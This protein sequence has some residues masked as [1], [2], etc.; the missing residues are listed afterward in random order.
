MSSGNERGVVYISQGLRAQAEVI[1][2]LRSLHQFHSW[3]VTVFGDLPVRGAE[4]I[5]VID[6]GR[7]GRF[8]K[9]S[10]GKLTPYKF[11]LFLD[12]DTRVLGDIGAGF[13]ILQDGWE[14]A[15][16]HSPPGALGVR[17]LVPQEQAT[18]TKFGPMPMCNT[19]VLYFR[20]CPSVDQFFTVWHNEWL[21]YRQHDQG[22]FL[23][24]MHRV[25]LRLWLLGRAYNSG[26]LV[27]HLFG[28]AR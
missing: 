23:R 7:P 13:D 27:Q 10:L 8:I 18:M 6:P 20:R 19:G 21:K 25:P 16:V 28:R 17:M 1:L 26:N 14:F 11:T 24:A 9:T 22:A 3:P 5:N 15:M 12:A 2:S 4:F